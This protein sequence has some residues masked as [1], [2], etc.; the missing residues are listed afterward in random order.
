MNVNLATLRRQVWQRIV[1]GYHGLTPPRLVFNALQEGLGGL[2]LFRDNI[3]QGASVLSAETL[4]AQIQHFQRSIPIKEPSAWIWVD[5]EGGPV[6]RLPW[7]MFP[8]LPSPWALGQYPALIH[9]AVGTQAMALRLLGF[10]SGCTPCLDINNEPDNPVIHVRS[11]GQT[12]HQVSQAGLAVLK[13]LQANR[14]MAMAKH[15]PGHGNS[16]LDSHVDRPV[17]HFEADMLAPFKA[18]IQA[19][20]PAVMVA[21]AAYPQLNARFNEPENTPASLSRGIIKTLLREELGFDGL[22]V[23]DDLSMGAVSALSQPTQEAAIQLA[24][25][26]CH[27]GN[28]ILLY[29][30][31]DETTEAIVEALMQSLM[32]DAVL[33]K[34]HEHALR[35]IQRAKQTYIADCASSS[36]DFV[37]PQ[38][39]FQAEAH[40]WAKHILTPR[41]GQISR[42]WQSRTQ[43]WLVPDRTAW[44][45]LAVDLPLGAPDFCEPFEHTLPGLSGG[46][47]QVVSYTQENPP[48]FS[49][50]AIAPDCLMVVVSC[51]PKMGKG[52]PALV[53]RMPNPVVWVSAGL[54]EATL[55]LE[56]SRLVAWLQPASWRP[57]V[58]RE[59]LRLVSLI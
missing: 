45:S 3:Q 6:E 20:L 51:L 7:T 8:S 12:S 16:K 1:A 37:W 59:C 14:V 41:M 28:D 44:H 39:A 34:Q 32:Q 33:M 24:L 15:F 26:A 38:E 46:R 5:Q 52:L 2:I 49:P 40:Q 30:T 19:N 31:L 4:R 22:V 55:P 17:L 23:T 56:A 50:L 48:D 29:R 13:A 36:D 57:V 53:S 54:P 9:Q 43:C 47:L 18:L 58:I 10:H 25:S 21:H 11:Y 27:A 42:P 35:R